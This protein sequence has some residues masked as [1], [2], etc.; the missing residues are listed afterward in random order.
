MSK[1]DYTK[2]IVGEPLKTIVRVKPPSNYLREDIKIMGSNIS[3]L[4]AN[5]RRENFL[6]SLHNFEKTLSTR[7]VRRPRSLRS[8]VFRATTVR[9]LANSLPKPFHPR[10]FRVPLRLRVVRQ[11][12]IPDN[13][14][15][16]ERTGINPAFLG[17]SV[18]SLGK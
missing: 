9:H 18:Q 14:R 6:I 10:V 4:D 7:G 1:T 13:R 8:G 3:L 16:Q 2:I 17:F 11:R 15:E 12:Q 5:N